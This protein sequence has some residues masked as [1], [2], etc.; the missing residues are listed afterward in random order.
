MLNCDMVRLQNI[1]CR[2]KQYGRVMQC[3]CLNCS[4]CKNY[5]LGAHFLGRK[6]YSTVAINYH[7]FAMQITCTCIP[8]KPQPSRKMFNN[9]V[10][11][12]LQL[13]HAEQKI[14]NQFF[15]LGVFWSKKQLFQ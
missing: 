12:A 1:N 6:L 10:L 13:M 5:K 14:N 3:T 2:V 11:F 7:L 15:K 4:V 9:E 8:G